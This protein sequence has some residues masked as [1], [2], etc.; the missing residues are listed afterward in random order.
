M[1]LT[2][3]ITLGAVIP[4]VVGLIELCKRVGLPTQFAPVAGLAFGIAGSF[5]F[6]QQTVAL[7]IF[8]GV[9]LGLSALGLYSGTKTT[10]G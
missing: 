6:P 7:T 10:V 3:V 1:D 4:A 2:Q 5:V 9:V 8:V